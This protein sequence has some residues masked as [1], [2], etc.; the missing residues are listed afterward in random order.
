MLLYRDVISGDEILS[1][2]FKIVEID[3]IAYEVNCEMVVI[4]EGDVDIGGNP[5][6]EGGEDEPLEDGAVTVNNVV[7]TFRLQST[8]FDKKGYMTYIKGYMKAVK[9]YLAANNPDRIPTFE[10]NITPFVKKILENFKDYEFYVGEGMN[11]DGMVVL[12]NYREDGTT[13]YMVLFK[14]GLKAEKLLRTE[15]AK[16]PE[17]RAVG[18]EEIPTPSDRTEPEIPPSRDAHSYMNTWRLAWSKWW[19]YEA[20]P[21]D[22]SHQLSPPPRPRWWAVVRNSWL[23]ETVAEISP[24]Q[25]PDRLTHAPRSRS[26][27]D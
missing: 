5:S 14:D 3:D 7:H 23:F 1:D 8:G 21:M 4:K 22:G 18:E 17:I 6:A 25:D 20:R 13:P 27:A 12:L 9:A 2:A 10:K 16:G 19:R 15:T 11:P 24:I 26:E